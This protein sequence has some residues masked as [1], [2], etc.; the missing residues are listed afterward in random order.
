MRRCLRLG[1]MV[2]ALPMEAKSMVLALKML[3]GVEAGEGLEVAGPAVELLHKLL[4]LHPVSRDSGL[5]GGTGSASHSSEFMYRD[6]TGYSPLGVA[7]THIVGCAKRT[8]PS[9]QGWTP[10]LPRQLRCC[11]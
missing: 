4:V 6:N 7:N 9:I 8:I 10:T 11:I 1:R 5:T 3:A 2:L